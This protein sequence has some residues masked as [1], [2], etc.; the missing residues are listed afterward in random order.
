[1]AHDIFIQTTDRG[2]KGN[3]EDK[4]FRNKLGETWGEL[5]DTSR[6]WESSSELIDIFWQ[7]DLISNKDSIA[8][9]IDYSCR[10]FLQS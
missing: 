8:K 10:A 9:L 5:A 6:T 1:M 7:I 4:I 3:E 2:H